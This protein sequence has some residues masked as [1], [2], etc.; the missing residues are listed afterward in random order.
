MSHGWVA[1]PITIGAILT[2]A[3]IN[4]WLTHAPTEASRQARHAARWPA[5][6]IQAR[7]QADTG[8]PHCG[9]CHVYQTPHGSERVPCAEH[10]DPVSAALEKEVAS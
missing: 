8:V 5:D 6:T 9:L 4:W 10:A 3:A 2:L 7:L 1:Y